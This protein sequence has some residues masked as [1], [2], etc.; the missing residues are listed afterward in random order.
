MKEGKFSDAYRYFSSDT[1]KR[2]KLN[3]FHGLMNKTR[4]GKLLQWKIQNWTVK[5]VNK[6]SPRRVFV[7]MAPPNKD[8][9]KNRYELIRETTDDGK[10]YWR[11]RFFLADELGMPRSDETYLFTPSDEE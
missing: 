9:P 6:E 3:H 7:T 11:I 2:Y 1:R 5:S 4:A 8:D 10:Q